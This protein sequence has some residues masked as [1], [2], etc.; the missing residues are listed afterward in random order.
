MTTTRFVKMPDISAKSVQEF[1]SQSEII[2]FQTLLILHCL[3]KRNAKKVDA[4]I[5]KVIDYVNSEEIIE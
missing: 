3:L 5:R 2:E 1:F 4:A